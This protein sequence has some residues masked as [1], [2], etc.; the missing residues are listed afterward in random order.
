MNKLSRECKRMPRWFAENRRLMWCGVASTIL[1]LRNDNDIRRLTYFLC[2]LLLLFTSLVFFSQTIKREIDLATARRKC[3]HSGVYKC[4]LDSNI[5]AIT[6]L[7]CR[8]HFSFY[9]TF[10]QVVVFDSFCVLCFGFCSSS[11][12]WM[13]CTE[14]MHCDNELDSAPI[15]SLLPICVAH[16][17]GIMHWDH[18][19]FATNDG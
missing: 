8:V 12:R 11:R 18:L 13:N 14:C 19:H 5:S 17:F 2:V 1:N 6:Q 4:A 3:L 16:C 10:I 7:Y 15:C 9:C